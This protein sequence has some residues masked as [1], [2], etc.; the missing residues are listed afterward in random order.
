MN[1][2][3]FLNEGECVSIVCNSPLTVAPVL[4]HSDNRRV[5]SSATLGLQIPTKRCAKL[6]YEV[7]ESV[8]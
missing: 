7:I 2:K 4:T 3:R 6:Q 8:P 1:S 5:S